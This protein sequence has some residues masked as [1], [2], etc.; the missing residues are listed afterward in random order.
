MQLACVSAG[1]NQAHD[2]VAEAT[3]AAKGLMDADAGVD[4]LA[5]PVQRVGNDLVI[6]KQ[7]KTAAKETQ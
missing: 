6:T 3:G 1:L 2:H 5:D 7:Y 4:I